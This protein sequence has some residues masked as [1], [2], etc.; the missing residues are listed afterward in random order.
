MA[1]P[2][3]SEV[4]AKPVRTCVM[5][6][7]RPGEECSEDYGDG[8]SQDSTIHCR[9]PLA[10][11]RFWKI[12]PTLPE[13]PGSA[14]SALP[15]LGRPRLAL[16]PRTLTDHTPPPLAPACAHSDTTPINTTARALPSATSRLP[17]AD[18]SSSLS[19]LDRGHLCP[20]ACA[21]LHHCWVCCCCSPRLFFIDRF[22]CVV[23]HRSLESMGAPHT[24]SC[25]CSSHPFL[26]S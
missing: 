26:V 22:L 11:S 17:R 14:C 5:R 23:T 20:R 2:A 7:N 4:T 25:I 3:T 1:P 13:S 21:V 19:Q 10:G 6:E 15:P 8:G 9:P 12:S 16:H 18:P 24:P